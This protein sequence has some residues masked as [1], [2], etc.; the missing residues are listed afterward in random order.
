MECKLFELVVEGG[1][2]GLRIHEK[3]RGITCSIFL[4]RSD[5]CW[6][7]DM[8]EELFVSE[9]FTGILEKVPSWLSRQFF[10]TVC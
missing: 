8:V 1:S 10:S 7:L 6:L 4:G 2:M 3:C 9:E 5:S